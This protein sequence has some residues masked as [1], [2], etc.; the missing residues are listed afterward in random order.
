MRLS[1]ALDDKK[2]DLRLRDKLLAEGK[3][4]QKDMEEY[5]KNLPDDASNATQTAEEEN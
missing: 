5:I 1:T 4:S 2:L 3:L